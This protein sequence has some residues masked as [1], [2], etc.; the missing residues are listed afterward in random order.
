MLQPFCTA[1][2]AQVAKRDALTIQEQTTV[3]VS[4]GTGQDDDAYE[5]VDGHV[6]MEGPTLSLGEGTI[7]VRLG[8]AKPVLSWRSP[9]FE[10]AS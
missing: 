1:C 8:V 9:F 7:G 4:R 3:V 2:A 5:S 10:A 6:T